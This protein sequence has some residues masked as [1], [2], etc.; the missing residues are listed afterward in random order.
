MI[1]VIYELSD[2]YTGLLEQFDIETDNI[3]KDSKVRYVRNTDKLKGW[4]GFDI[5]FSL[6]ARMI[7]D[8][9]NS[10]IDKIHRV[11]VDTKLYVPTSTKIQEY[12]KGK[13]PCSKQPIR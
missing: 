13:I 2:I 8:L 1:H 3:L 9:F 4:T 6:M 7:V 11:L 10:N 5:I 12:I